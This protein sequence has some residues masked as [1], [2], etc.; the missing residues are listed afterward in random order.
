MQALLDLV[1]PSNTMASLRSFYDSV[2]NHIRGLT[3]WG[4]QRS[5]MEHFSFL[6]YWENYL[7]KPEEIWP[8]S[9]QTWSGPSMN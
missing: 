4:S 3:A 1:G 9:T 7:L 6:L 5:H 8:G 2:E